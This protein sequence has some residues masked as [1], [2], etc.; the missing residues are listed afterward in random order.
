MTHFFHVETGLDWFTQ[1]W[2]VNFEI[3]NTQRDKKYYSVHFKIYSG[4]MSLCA[5][6]LI[7]FLLYSKIQNYSLN[8]NIQVLKERLNVVFFDIYSKQIAK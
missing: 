6:S 8:F 4:Y 7:S 3:E 5:A 2:P 1:Q